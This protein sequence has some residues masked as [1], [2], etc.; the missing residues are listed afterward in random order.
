MKKINIDE[1][2][3]NAVEIIE[4]DF[5]YIDGKYLRNFRMKLQFSQTIFADYLG[6]S[7][8]TINNWEQ[9]KYK[10]NAIATRLIYLLEK[11]PKNLSLLKEIKLP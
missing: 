3:K 6:V 9:R 5:S 10:I 8:K 1:I 7:K 11:E 2:K 4:P